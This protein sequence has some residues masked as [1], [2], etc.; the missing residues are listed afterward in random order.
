MAL[1]IGD[2]PNRGKSAPPPGRSKPLP[3]PKKGGASDK[4]S[5]E[6]T[7]RIAERNEA[8]SGWTPRMFAAPVVRDDRRDAQ[9]QYFQL[10]PAPTALAPRVSERI[11]GKQTDA[12]TYAPRSKSNMTKRTPGTF[13]TPFWGGLL[14]KATD[15]IGGDTSA[16]D[17]RF[18]TDLDDQMTRDATGT[19]PDGQPASVFR[20]TFEDTRAEKG[21]AQNVQN[22]ADHYNLM[23]RLGKRDQARMDRE[24]VD[25]SETDDVLTA[26]EWNNLTPLQ[27]A[28]VQAN[29]DLATAI[30]RDFDTQSRHK[31]SDEQF[32]GYQKRVTD[33]FG[34]NAGTGFKGLEYAPNTI[35][36]L[37]K[38]GIDKA[39]LAGKTLDDLIS[40]D[41]LMGM[42][43]IRA[44]EKPTAN[45]ARARNVTFAKNLAAGQLQYQED[46]AARLKRGDQLLNDITGRDAASAATN[47]YGA[48]E[49]PAR[50]RLS[51][52][53]PETSQLLD[54]YM[55]ILARTD[56]DIGKAIDTIHADLSERGSSDEERDQVVQALIERTRQATTG[57][58]KWFDGIDF[59]M[60][61]PTDVAAALGA[62]TLKRRG[63][64]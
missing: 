35:S 51:A 13:T 12:L 30:K 26:E 60:R 39:E 44:L 37:D 6:F 56:S 11:G 27:Q 33:L 20:G 19:S 53:R 43:D 2:G 1:T 29:A 15:F 38:R 50:A 47:S 17:S 45:D 14:D 5:Q 21:R 9:E 42:E 55:E 23:A 46:L 36:F 49:L 48:K 58:G 18:F 59:P 34:E 61:A 4:L 62:T 10:M 25:R 41:A 64:K 24:K 8:T 3:K 40:G 63:A 32:A 7:R 57:E 16:A 28:A 22:V 54:T 52:V 31:S